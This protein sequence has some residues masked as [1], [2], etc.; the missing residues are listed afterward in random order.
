MQE[1][2]DRARV[3]DAVF[4]LRPDYRALLIAVDGLVPGPSDET[5]DTL[6]R[7]AEASARL[8]DRPVEELP[9]IASWREAYR[10]FGA[11]PQR[12]RNSAEALLRRAQ[13]GLPRVNRLTDVYNAI[14]VLHQIPVG[15]EDLSRYVGAPRLIRAEGSEAFDTVA[16]GEDATEHPAAGEVVWCDDIGV[17]CR[18]WNWRQGRRTQLT[19]ATT[20]ALFILD[21]LDPLTDEHLI[22]V[23]D[24]LIEHLLRI[25]PD[26][27]VAKRLIASSSTAA[28]AGPED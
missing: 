7:A 23:A 26:V 12:T 14:S 11:K 27:R 24:E 1:V 3:E 28:A 4:A 19:E 15:G 2:L 16:G 22:T 18:R 5:S 21:I 17:T 13:D 10:A 20:T 9:H 6:L 25:G 8:T